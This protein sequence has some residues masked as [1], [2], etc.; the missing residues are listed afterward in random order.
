M[1]L[2]G[3]RYMHRLNYDPREM[4]EMFQELSRVSAAA[5]ARV[6][7]WASTHPDPENRQEKAL[8]RAATLTLQELAA[9]VVGRDGYLRRLDGL[10]FAANPREGF[11]RGTQFLHPDLRFEFTFPTGWATA[12]QK[13]AVMAMSPNQDAVIR[14]SGAAGSSP[15]AAAQQFFGGEGVSGTSSAYTVNGLQAVGGGF[16]ATQQDGTLAGRVMFVAHGGTVLQVTGFG[17]SDSW[18]GYA[19]TVA[20]AMQTFRPLTDQAALSAQPWH[21]TIVRLDRTMTPQQFAQR[22][23]GPV[24][25]DELAII[26]QVDPDG[27]YMNQ[28][29]A[30]RVVGQVIR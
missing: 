21:I 18:S 7:E 11:F 10:M 24:S 13:A 9:A 15:A 29:L 27:R 1:R 30:K 17:T 5:G 25:A 28:N 16:T 19:G 14:I 26:N 8:E 23:P 22:Y 3:F 20:A 2:E 12:N 6:P 4:A